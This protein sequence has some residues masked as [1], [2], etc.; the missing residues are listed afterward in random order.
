MPIIK[1]IST[2]YRFYFVSHDCTE[3]PHV[4][5]QKD[6][7]TAKIWLNVDKTVRLEEPNTQG[8]KSHE[9][10]AILEIVK[11]NFDTIW[12]TFHEHCKDYTG[13]PAP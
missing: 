2:A 8:F 11:T 6:K 9:V 1:S 10:N 7:K 12:N 3:K 5:V 4:H 13:K